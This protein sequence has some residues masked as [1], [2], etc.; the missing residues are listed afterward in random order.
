MCLNT[1]VQAIP[2]MQLTWQLVSV[3][4]EILY[5]QGVTRYY[6]PLSALMKVVVVNQK[7]LTDSKATISPETA[8]T[9][10]SKLR[11]T[12][13]TEST[14]EQQ[15]HVEQDR[16]GMGKNWATGLTIGV[17]VAVKLL[18]WFA[19]QRSRDTDNSADDLDGEEAA[20]LSQLKYP[21]P[22]PPARGCVVPPKNKQL[23]PLCRGNRVHPCISTG[24]Y[25]FCYSCLL[26]HIEQVSITCPVTGLYCSEG[27]IIRLYD[28]NSPS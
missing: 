24:G 26:R 18:Q 25:V 15:I 3:L 20:K 7:H 16:E 9:D 17:V 28:E 2:S 10:D 5:L 27:D 19:Q 23:C 14:Q 1:I 13:D 8:T 12:S 6:H 4:F 11:S 22:L 21:S